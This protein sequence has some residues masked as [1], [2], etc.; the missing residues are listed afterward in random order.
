MKGRRSHVMAGLLA[1]ILMS[2]GIASAALPR[3]YFGLASVGAAAGY[4]G[5]WNTAQARTAWWDIN[6]AAVEARWVLNNGLGFGLRVVDGAGVS[7]D[8]ILQFRPHISTYAA[9]AP[10]VLWV[11]HHSGHGFGFLELQ[12]M[13]YVI[14][15][16]GAALD[17]V[18]VPF[19]PWPIEL[20]ARA[21]ATRFSWDPDGQIGYQLA[22]GF[23][24][25]LGWWIMQP[26]R[27]F[28]M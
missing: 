15:A 1:A 13:P 27:P 25:G 19:A 8:S 12:V 6:G 4:H 22:A 3:A 7:M 5:W 24:V 20:R 2:T 11:A 10:S 18:Y 28:Q 21:A 26:E 17:Y 16:S 23:R 9:L 14:G